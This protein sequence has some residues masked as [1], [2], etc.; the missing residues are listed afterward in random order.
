MRQG[1]MLVATALLTVVTACGDDDGSTAAPPE[2]TSAASTPPTTGALA[3]PDTSAAPDPGTGRQT[4]HSSGA[5]D[6]RITDVRA[7]ERDGGTRVVVTFAGT[8]TPG[9]AARYVRRAV[10]EGSGEVA[11]LDGD[12]ILRLDVSGTPTMPE[13]D[14]PIG[15]EAEGDVVDLLAIGAWEGYS[16]VFVGLAGQRVPFA[17]RALADPSRIVIDLG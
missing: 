11:P 12:T 5:Y 10:L 2:A 16:Q 3:S 13:Q 14:D 15:T 9:W 4:Q 6:L 17:V 1:R 8:G 7:R